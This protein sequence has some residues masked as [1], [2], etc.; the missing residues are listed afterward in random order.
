[1]QRDPPD[2]SATRTDWQRL[3]VTSDEDI[4][5]AVEL[6]P[7][8]APILPAEELKTYQPAPAQKTRHDR[9]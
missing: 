5:R 7:D 9:A 6:D 4:A 3:R 2:L 8:A 1:M